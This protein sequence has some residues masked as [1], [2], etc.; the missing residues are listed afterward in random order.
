MQ[1]GEIT[2]PFVS[3]LSDVRH[4]IRSATAPD[5]LDLFPQGAALLRGSWGMNLV[6][7]LLGYAFHIAVSLPSRKSTAA[8]ASRQTDEVLNEKM[9]SC[10]LQ[11][12][13]LHIL[14]R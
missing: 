6:Y 7:V 12:L 3:Q 10:P 9:G 2:I 8:T 5:G 11:K 4:R 1:R 14:P 13:D